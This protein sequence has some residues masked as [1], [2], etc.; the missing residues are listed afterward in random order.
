MGKELATELSREELMKRKEL[1]MRGLE[2]S[3]TGNMT[4]EE[5]MKYGLYQTREVMLDNCVV[6]NGKF[7]EKEPNGVALYKRIVAERMKKQNRQNGKE[8]RT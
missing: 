8:K 3:K 4:R 7:Y 2:K 5:L 6:I 1:W